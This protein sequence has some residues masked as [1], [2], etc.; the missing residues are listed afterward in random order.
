MQTILST[1]LSIR[2]GAGGEAFF[3]FT[4]Q[5]QWGGTDAAPRYKHSLP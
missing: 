3:P 1:P 4:Y 2:R 5:T